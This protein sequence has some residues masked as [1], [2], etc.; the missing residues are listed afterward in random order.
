[1]YVGR[2]ENFPDTHVFSDQ[3]FLVR[4]VRNVTTASQRTTVVQVEKTYLRRHDAGLTRKRLRMD[5]HFEARGGF[6]ELNNL[7]EGTPDRSAV[8]CSATCFD[9]RKIQMCHVYT[10]AV[11]V[12]E[13]LVLLDVRFF[14]NTAIHTFEHSARVI[15][16]YAAVFEMDTLDNVNS[17]SLATTRTMHGF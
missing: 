17:L 4:Q 5:A 16:L 8:R 12:E 10:T 2:I 13:K 9:H 6:L 7:T 3:I 11:D 15:N 1:M 14:K